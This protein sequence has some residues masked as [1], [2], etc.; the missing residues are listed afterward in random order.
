MKHKLLLTLLSAAVVTS[1]SAQGKI[2][3]AGME[4]IHNYKAKLIEAASD[5]DKRTLAAPADQEVGVLMELVPGA[6]ESFLS[7]LALSPPQVS[8]PF[9]LCQCP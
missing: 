8:A 2:N 7:E 9:C 1:A 4:M 3:F 6:N 5:A